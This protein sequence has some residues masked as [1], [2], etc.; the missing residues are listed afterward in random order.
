LTTGADL[1]EMSAYALWITDRI[2]FCDT[3]QAGH[4][5]NVAYA[6]YA[7]T[8]RLD[9]MDRHVRPLGVQGR[10]FIAA[11][12]TVNFLKETHY[13]GEVRI[14]TGIARVGRT[15]LTVGQGIFKDDLCVA[16]ALGSVVYLD[17]STPIPLTDEMRVVLNG[18]LIA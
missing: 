7:E 5:N 1:T 3:D 2:R 17:G 16:T 11:S 14:G 9:F 13:P 8:G 12:V 4:V 6:A 10:R 15:S 18:L